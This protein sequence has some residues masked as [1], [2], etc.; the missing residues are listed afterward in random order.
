MFE[1][2]TQTLFDSATELALK[3]ALLAAVSLAF[4]QNSAQ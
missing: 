2:H 1:I 4:P 3:Q